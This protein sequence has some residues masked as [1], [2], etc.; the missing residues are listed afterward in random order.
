MKRLT[1]FLGPL[2]TLL[3]LALG[4][5]LGQSYALRSQSYQA[6]NADESVRFTD[7]YGGGSGYEFV[8]PNVAEGLSFEQA[9][10][11][12]QSLQERRA[13]KQFAQIDYE[14]GIEA[15]DQPAIGD[16]ADGAENSVFSFVRN[17]DWDTLRYS[18]ALKG[19][20]EKQKA[21]LVFRVERGGKDA[22]YRFDLPVNADKARKSLQSAGIAF[23]TLVPGA[24]KTHVVIFDSEGEVLSKLSSLR[25]EYRGL[26][27]SVDRGRGEFIGGDS[28]EEGD[29]AYIGV[30]DHYRNL[31]G[32]R[33]RARGFRL[34][35]EV[36]PWP[37][38]QRPAQFSELGFQ[39][40]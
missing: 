35:D 24:R 29:R 30:I 13:L 28:Y 3:S 6:S 31:R 27:I 19:Q 34:A 36:A 16:W 39:V 20:A 26:K 33:E 10:A 22:V 1:R 11:R 40:G 9:F 2:C 21:V 14:L 12:L 32:P 18:A 38:F 15:H 25:K 23:H 17:A 4:P 8:S 7:N 37:L 5:Q